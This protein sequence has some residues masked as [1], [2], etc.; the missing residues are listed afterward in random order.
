ML[1]TQTSAPRVQYPPALSTYLQIKKLQVF[2]VLRR[3]SFTGQIVWSAPAGHQWVLF[4]NQGHVVYGTGGIHPMRQWYRQVQAHLPHHDLSYQALQQLALHYPS[5]IL[6]NCWDYNLLHAWF[7]QGQLTAQAFRAISANI[8]AD[9][10]VDVIQ[11][12]ET[13]YQL[14]RHPTFTPSQVPIHLSETDLLPSITEFWQGW[15]EAGLAA[16]SPNLAPIIRHPEPIQAEVSP[17]VYQSLMQML[18]GQRSLRDLAVKFDKPVLPLTQALQPFI[19]AGWISLVPVADFPSITGIGSAIASVAHSDRPPRIVCV[20]D[21]PMIC[22]AMGQVIRAAGYDFASVTEGARAVP[23]LLAQPPDLVFLDL[24]MPDT[25]GYEICS[26]LRKISRF[27]A[28]PIIILSGNDGLVDQVRA[29]LLG[30][31]DFLSKPIEPIVILS[32]I[33]KH[34]Q[35]L[36]CA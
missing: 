35:S 3:L 15:A 14:I 29:R 31:T 27:Q 9:I 7:S 16:C 12:A 2:A 25:S 21:S 13:Q 26:N 4:F 24:V 30:A 10:L 1:K 17:R 6:P 34:L 32:I 11:A 18:D 23:T 5:Y 20:D 22:K 8:V 36:A 28:V 33:S 19:K